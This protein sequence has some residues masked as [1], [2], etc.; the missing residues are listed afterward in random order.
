[1]TNEDR[2]A[3]KYLNF[4]VSFGLAMGI[5]I[6]LLYLGGS[7]LDARLGTTPL[8]MVLGILLAIVTVFKRLISDIKKLSNK[9]NNMEIKKDDKD[10]IKWE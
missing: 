1:M 9:T 10:R 6:Y 2:S 3:F 4:G 5:A 7:W 8:F